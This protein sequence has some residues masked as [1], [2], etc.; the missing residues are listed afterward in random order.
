[1]AGIS[2]LA[3]D[4]RKQ[5]AVAQ[6]RLLLHRQDLLDVGHAEAAEGLAGGVADA[7]HQQ[8]VAQLGAD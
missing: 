5:A 3:S 4:S 1:M 2:R 8:V 7:Q 6:A